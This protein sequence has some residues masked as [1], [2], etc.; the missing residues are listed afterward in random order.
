VKILVHDNSGH[1]FQ[2]QLSRGLAARGHQVVHSHCEAY[3]SGKGKLSPAEGDTAQ[4]V[5]I[6]A[7]QKVDKYNF[8]RRLFHEAFLGRELAGVIRARRPDVVL[9]ANTP[10]PSL[11]V[12]VAYLAVARIPWVLWHQDVYAVALQGFAAKRKSTPLLLAARVMN[13]AERWCARQARH[14]VVIADA[15]R[16]VHARWGT[17]DKTTVI[18]NWA[19]LDE[20]VPGE[21][22]NRWAAEHEVADVPTLL[23]SGTLGLKHNPALLVA[24][25]RRVREL[26]TDVHLVVVTEGP[27][28]EVL[29]AAADHGEVPLTVLPFQ[30][31]DRLSEV[32]ASGD[33]LVVLLEPDASEFSVPSKTLSYLCAGRP[34]VGLMPR[35]NAAAAL[36]ERADCKVLAPLDESIAAAARWVVEQ[37]AMPQR[38]GE[39]GRGAR[40]L[41]EQEFSL[42]RTVAAFEK[43]LRQ[44]ALRR[45]QNRVKRLPGVLFENVAARLRWR[46]PAAQPKNWINRMGR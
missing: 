38:A 2:A 44:A 29:R 43:L 35:S 6:G 19:P 13:L 42:E 3:V 28:V 11:V 4:F 5:V 27:T 46:L 24:L 39:I 45:Q 17:L 26:G 20:I 25:A 21:R 7:G 18:P 41:A 36:L 30:P 16:A 10:L 22:T 32:L 31:Y 23:Y 1:P 37:L 12:V 14:I 15:F 33:V 40:G 34:I 9:I 8:V